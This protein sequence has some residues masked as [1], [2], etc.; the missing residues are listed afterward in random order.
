MDSKT[1]TEAQTK[2][3]PSRCEHEGCKKK[4]G[5]TD[6]PCKC[7]HHYCK[8]HRICEAH[9]CTFDFFKEGQQQLLKYMSSPVIGPKVMVI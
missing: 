6:F 4:I 1:Q 9:Q 3:K 7:G 5:L 8:Q 2:K